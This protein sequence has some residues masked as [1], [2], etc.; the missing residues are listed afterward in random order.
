M[1]VSWFQL[2]KAV[3]DAK[4]AVDSTQAKEWYKSQTIWYNIIKA[5]VTVSAACG[6]ALGLAQ[7]DLQ[8]VSTA[9][10]VVVPAVCTVL[11]MVANIW[12]RL[13]TAAPINTPALKEKA[14]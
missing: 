14:S 4:A 10:A 2:L 12:L 7:E 9:L 1:K 13:R 3:P 11:D 6:I 5:V 8:T